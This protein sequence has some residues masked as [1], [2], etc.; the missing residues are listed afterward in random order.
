MDVT[1]CG[2]SS[3][4]PAR[5]G[6]WIAA[7]V[8]TV[9]SGVAINQVY[10]NDKWLW[11][12]LGVAV[13][14]AGIAV[15]TSQ[16]LTAPAP[17]AVLAVSDSHGDPPL[18]GDVSLT[19]LGVHPNRYTGA[20]SAGYVSR[21]C[22]AAL[23][24]ALDG[25]G[26]LVVVHGVRLAG[27]TRTL[28]E[29][30][31]AGLSQRRVL[32]VNADPELDWEAVMAL[33]R[34]WGSRGD[35]AVLWLD[36]LTP[37]GLM[38]LG[39]RLAERE[40]PAGLL[41]LAT[42]HRDPTNDTRLPA[43][44]KQVLG[45][46]SLVAVGVLSAVER[47]GLRSL[48]AYA[49]L[50]SVVEAGG[51][52]L[53]GRLLVSLDRIEAALDLV[54]ET[55]TDRVALLRLVTDWQRLDI[56][57]RLTRKRMARL[58]EEYWRELNGLPK[59]QPVPVSGFK[60]A[61]AWATE[62]PSADRPQLVTPIRVA[63]GIHHVSHPLLLSA[64][65]DPSS[66]VAWS[67]SECLWSWAER[68]LELPE[69]LVMG[70][71]AFQDLDFAHARQMLEDS[72][73]DGLVAPDIL[74]NVALW[75][76][77]H[78]ELD[79]ARCWYT[80]AVHSGHPDEAPRAMVGLGVL[81]DGQGNVDEAR[82]WYARAIESGHPD[83]APVAMVNLGAIESERGNIDEARRW[84]TGAIESGHPEVAPGAMVNLGVI[85]SGQGNVDEAR[86][87]YTRAIESGHTDQAPKAMAG[88][89]IIESGLGN[90][91]EARRWYT[92]AIGSGHPD[93][94]PSAMAGLGI[95]ESGRGNFDEA[96]RWYTGAIESGHPGVAPKAMG[97][98]GNLE[99]R[100]GN[101]DAAR[102]WYTRAIGSGHPDAAPSAMGGLG[103]LESRQGNI[104]AAR[105]WYTR[106]IDS[107]HP[108]VAPLAMVNLGL[109]ED[110]QG[111]VDEA[112][113]WYT[114]VIGSGHPEASSAQRRLRKL[115][116]SQEEHRRAQ[117]AIRG[118][119]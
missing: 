97:G 92:G 98:L 79:Q 64:A 116:H 88:L 77:E 18:L 85:E 96:R 22:D 86:R 16:L 89:G 113:R 118:G 68:E 39:P 48:P 76:E 54:D 7:V 99:S 56:P 119:Y 14:F 61:L 117:E 90:V 23:L 111:N 70:L 108:D 33:S 21:D 69:R 37:R 62:P 112:R 84:Y 49:Q 15:K 34:D 93:A 74:F 63:G 38:G 4:R 105:G 35:G 17:R 13:I 41:V 106:A 59:G 104:D 43:Q 81:E 65:D 24:E 40:L 6:V 87:W 100:Q 91:D 32:I 72:I 31:K 25:E 19:D 26:Q 101:I 1:L 50:S 83:A 71:A 114:R 44:A 29:A 115:D 103:N 109:L 55:A 9:A 107:G 66:D 27:C 47:L 28:V 78:Q 82:R 102:G 110:G 11:W 51:A 36:A 30:A 8:A 80:Q 2:V 53:M 58:Y 94:V 20:G 46:A 3:M 60:R 52:Q 10:S 67:V 75:L 73:G 12:W 95:I 42:M 5:T 45:G 57:R